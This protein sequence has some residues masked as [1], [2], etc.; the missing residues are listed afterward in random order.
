MGLWLKTVTLPVLDHVVTL[1]FDLKFSEI[2]NTTQKRSLSWIKDPVWDIWM[3]LWLQN[4]IYAHIWSCGVL[5]FWPLDFK[6]SEMLK[7]TPVSLFHWWKFLSP[8]WYTWM[9]L[10]LQNCGGIKLPCKVH[11]KCWILN[12][13]QIHYCHKLVMKKTFDNCDKTSA[14]FKRF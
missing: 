11:I 12:G 14:V 8:V 5:D 4:C 10:W 2:L 7:I 1:T 13:K 3:E 6:L 9:E